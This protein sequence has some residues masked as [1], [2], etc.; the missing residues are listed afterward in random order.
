V[1]TPEEWEGWR[2]HPLSLAHHIQRW[3]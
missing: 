2:E 1:Y 3:G